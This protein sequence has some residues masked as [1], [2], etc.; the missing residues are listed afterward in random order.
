MKDT[1][2]EK[3]LIFIRVL[4]FN[5]V[6]TITIFMVGLALKISW[7]YIVALMLTFFLTRAVCGKL[8]DGKPKH[9]KKAY[10]CFIWSTLVFTSVYVI[11]DLHIYIIILLTIFTA[12]IST[13]KA[14]IND[15]Y[16][17]KGNRSKYNALIN[18]VSLSP[19]NKILLEHEEYWRNNYP[20]RYEIF[21][22]F[23]RERKTYEDIVEELDLPDTKVIQRECKSIYDILERPLGLP[24][25]E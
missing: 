14:D 21:T 18:L 3:I 13:G 24:S 7:N 1:K 11:T 6:E 20:I 10:Q 19:N 23:F 9:Y 8:F 15:L 17:W 5:I 25:I 22:L 2:V 12:F 16:M 4:L